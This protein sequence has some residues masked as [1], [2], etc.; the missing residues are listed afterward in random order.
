MKKW[1]LPAFCILLIACL[2]INYLGSVLAYELALP[3]WLDSI[4]TVLAA[5]MC[6]PVIGAL[7]GVTTN[8]IFHIVTG[9]NWIY[10]AVSIWVGLVVGMVSLKKQRRMSLFEALTLSGVVA[11]GC[12]VIATPLSW[13]LN[14]G[15]TGNIWGDS[16]ISF[17]MENGFSRLPSLVVGQLYMEL[18][19]K[20]VV[21]LLI[22]L[23]AY[24]VF[25]R[26]NKK[27]K[28]LEAL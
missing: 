6:G 23:V 11:L 15:S 26:H 25:K 21:V 8:L 28:Q 7:T 27:Q 19:D 24:F 1:N 13:Y 10:A 9:D 22:Y 3:V 4:G 20:V 17:L 2:G 14:N 5:Y 12:T 16:V 18:L